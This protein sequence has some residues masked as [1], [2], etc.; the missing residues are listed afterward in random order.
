LTLPGME[1]TGLGGLPGLNPNPLGNGVGEIGGVSQTA[2][3]QGQA[4]LESHLAKQEAA[5]L[6]QSLGT[7]PKIA[8]FA[9][10]T[11][12]GIAAGVAIDVGWNAVSQGIY[13][14]ETGEMAPCR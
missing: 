7:G 14:H 12:V 3:A 13:F 9:K 1:G 10:A 4:Q 2:F 11:I 5:R 6:A 8:S